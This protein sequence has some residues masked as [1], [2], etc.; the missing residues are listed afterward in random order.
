MA[1]SNLGAYQTMVELAKKTNGPVKLGIYILA[2]GVFIG[3]VA[4]AAAGPAVKKGASR[5]VASVRRRFTTT[6]AAAG[7][8]YTVSTGADCGAGNYLQVGDRF[9][10]VKEIEEGV[11]IVLVGEDEPFGMV[12][13]ALLSSISD[14][15]RNGKA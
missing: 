11:L 6:A 4:G 3:S 14:F 1:K 2:G 5:T 7:R 9:R 12:D 13:P 10:I 15:R 8:V